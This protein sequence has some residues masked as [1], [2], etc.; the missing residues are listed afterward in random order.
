[1]PDD[2]RKNISGQIP[3]VMPVPTR[4]DEYSADERRNFP[5]LFEFDD[6]HVMHPGWHK[7]PKD[8]DRPPRVRKKIF[9][10]QAPLPRYKIPRLSRV[11]NKDIEN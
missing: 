10:L 5:R 7:L 8:P 6:D 1:M 11:N 2:V 4:L 9:A 3:Q